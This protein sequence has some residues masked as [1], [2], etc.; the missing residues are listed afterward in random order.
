MEKEEIQVKI[1]AKQ[2]L[3][4]LEKDQNRKNELMHQLQVLQMRKD[5]ADSQ[6]KIKHLTGID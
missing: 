6:D 1:V 5:I 3:I 2:E 4:N